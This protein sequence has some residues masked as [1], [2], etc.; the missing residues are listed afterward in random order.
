MRMVLQKK[1]QVG[2]RE[3]SPLRIS[4]LGQAEHDERC[5]ARLTRGLGPR[6]PKA[7]RSPKCSKRVVHSTAEKRARLEVI[8]EAQADH[9]R[10]DSR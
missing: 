10:V 1:R 4:G 6:A 5:M 8:C 7:T 2:D 9:R 3:V